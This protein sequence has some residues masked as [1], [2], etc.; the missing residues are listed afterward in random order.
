[1]EITWLGQGGFLLRAGEARI[2]VD[3]YLSDALRE[4]GMTRMIPPPLSVKELAPTLV[5]A[6]HDHADHFDPETV[7]PLATRFPA[8]T[9]AGPTSV[10]DHAHRLEIA[11]RRLMPLLASGGVLSHPPF[12]L[13]ATPAFHS[14]AHAIGLLVETSDARLYISG[15]TTYDAA[16]A[17]GIRRRSAERIDLALI[18]INGRLG[19]MNGE[20]AVRVIKMLQPAAAAPM[21]YGLFAANTA[22]PEPFLTGVKA[23][24]IRPLRLES[25]EPC[26]VPLP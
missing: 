9:F 13:Y 21:H 16:V 3:P 19:N 22:D 15:D 11:D 10:L 2:A 25:G 26:A 4:T 1:M 17:E 23:L 5:V 8:C 6:T 14:D 12:T 18:C 20:E 7:L 24:G